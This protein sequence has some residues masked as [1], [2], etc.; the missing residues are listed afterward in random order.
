MLNFSNKYNV[1]LPSTNKYKLLTGILIIFMLTVSGCSFINFNNT[2]TSPNIISGELVIK[3]NYPASR[4]DNTE[5]IMPSTGSASSFTALNN[6]QEEARDL[7]IVLKEDIS[8]NRINAI[9]NT[10]NFTKIDENPSLNA[11]LIK[12]PDYSNEEAIN[13]AS[14]IS[15]IKYIEPNNQATALNDRAYIP[16]DSEYNKQWNLSLIRLP[17]TWNNLNSANRIRVAV[18]DT[19][20]DINH[21][22]LRTNLDTGNAYNFVNNNRNIND[23][24]PQGHGTHVAGLIGAQRNN[25]GIAGILKNVEVLPIKVLEGDRGGSFWN[26]GQGLLYAAGIEVEGGPF[27]PQPVDIINLSLGGTIDAETGKYLHD[28]IKQVAA[29]GIIM[30]AASGNRNQDSLVYPAA[31]PEVLSVGSVS[32][33]NNNPPTRTSTSN[34]GSQL[35]FVAPGHQIYST[36]PDGNYQYLSGTSMAAPHLTGIIGLLLAQENQLGFEEIKE[37][38]QR[39]SMKIEGHY[40]GAETGY[41]LINSYWAIQNVD[42][43]QVFIGNR[44]GNQFNKKAGINLQLRDNSYLIE[45]IPTGSYKIIAWI[46]V[47]KNGVLS[48]G[49]YYAES[50][51]IN[52][53]QENNYS[54]NLILK[55]LKSLE[56]LN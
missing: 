6:L 38:L 1:M 12:A 27:N 41:G 22:E 53:N 24:H 39:T 17:Q 36:I 16:L 46:D 3:H 31:Y 34:Y 35:D 26:I 15:E 54:Q 50:Q 7:I 11:Y 13:L 8:T 55:E 45:D 49:D 40:F 48:P 28:V 2:T 56:D 52:F 23:S 21:P 14:R 33:D 10:Y 9:F 43:L 19:G 47:T 30:I 29:K 4:L 5:Y 37:R 44:E 51:V 20:V 18:L 25:L 42:K 32:L